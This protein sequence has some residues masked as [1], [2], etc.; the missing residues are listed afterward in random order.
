GIPADS[1][2]YVVYFHTRSGGYQP[3]GVD[4]SDASDDGRRNTSFLSTGGL[5]TVT[6]NNG[7]PTNNPDF[8][9]AFCNAGTSTGGFTA[10]FDL[11]GAG[12]NHATVTHSRTGLGTPVVEFSVPLASLGIGDGGDVDF[13]AVEISRTGF[14]SNEGLPN[15]NIGSNPGFGGTNVYADFHRFTVHYTG[16]AGP[17]TSRVNNTTL[18]MPQSAPATTTNSYTTTNIF[19]TLSTFNQPLCIRTPPG[20]TNRM[21]VV[22][23]NG[24]IICV[25]NLASPGKATFLDISAK[26]LGS[27]GTEQGLLSLDFH[28][29]FA[30]N[31]YFF[32]WYVSN[33][34][35][36]AGTGPHD[37]LARF[38]VSDTNA[39]F[40]SPTTEV[41]F[42]KQFD[43]A[44]NHNGGDIHFGPDGYLYLSMGDEGSGNDSFNNTQ[45]ITNDFF[46]G[47]LRIDVD[48]LPGSVAPNP[49]AAIDGATTNYAIP[50]D[51][52]YV[53][54]T[55]FN[56]VVIGATNKIR[57]EYW[58][59]GLRNPFRFCFDTVTGDL[60]LG[61]VGQDAREEVSLIVRGGNYGWAFREGCIPTSVGKPI[62]TGYNQTN[63]LQNSHF[64]FGNGL[65]T[66]SNWIRGF[67]TE[68]REG[69]AG[70]GYTLGS[71]TFPNGTNALKEYGADSDL[72]QTNLP[73]F[74]NSNYLARGLFYHSSSADVITGTVL[75]T[76]MFMEIEWF[77]T[78]NTLVG[79]S[80]SATHN[81]ATLA[82]QW[83]PIE[84]TMTSPASASRATFH[85]KSDCNQCA[86]SVWADRFYFGLSTNFEWSYREPLLDYA[87]SGSST[88]IG[89]TV[90]GGMVYRGDRFPEL[91]G[92]YIF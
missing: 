4:M 59:V 76:R 2:Q 17:P 73:V 68:T 70:F 63:L 5:E 50:P 67:S 82:D 34:S 35:T 87:R 7:G 25:T 46:A 78:N 21:F 20:E 84:L 64:A 39:N 53:G 51:N 81:G 89:T 24:L 22:E 91:V 42:I 38:K 8:A 40:C 26:T 66:I 88:N 77:D 14:L 74:G 71:G 65:N 12:T 75:S 90:T 10:L 27:G 56:G 47:M 9:L 43:D 31:G 69:T 19:P 28:P 45:R 18:R 58:A 11:R 86:G 29:G 13:A 16:P 36:P 62:P 48:K 57:A 72:Y 6:F 52:P 61:D 92:N 33:T 15:P 44:D 85:I 60:L 54:A 79:A 30:T 83:H 32:V 49:H 3:N 23:K 55:Q 80:T 37:I 1:N 41:T